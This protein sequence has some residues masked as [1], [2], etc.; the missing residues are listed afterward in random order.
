MVLNIPHK[1][2]ALGRDALVAIRAV[3]EQVRADADVR[4]LLVTAA[5]EKTFCAGAALD[6]MDASKA[7]DDFFAQTMAQIADLAVPTVCAIN[8]NVF[9]GGVELA[10]SC[11]FRIGIEGSR[12]RVPAAAIGLCYPL[13]GMQRF[14]QTLGPRV[15]KRLLVAAEEFDASSML[16]I[17][18]LDHVVM[19]SQLVSF[20]D[21]YASDIAAL[22][23]LA[24]QSMKQL[25]QQA[26][27]GSIDEEQAQVL[28]ER[29]AASE[30][31]L[32]GFAAKSE[33]RLPRFKGR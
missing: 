12:M 26:A 8:G 20:A 24:V 23:P 3:L 9:G 28:A 31:L 1:H 33:R 14:L 27:A 13:I 2:N 18:F 6:E 17:G 4:V 5:G 10:L 15:S 22:A 7:T 25:L 30:D 16:Q 21:A 29:C 32:E 11:D 19:R